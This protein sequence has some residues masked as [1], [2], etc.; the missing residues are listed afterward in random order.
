VRGDALAINLLDSGRREDHFDAWGWAETTYFGPK[1]GGVYFAKDGNH[2]LRV[3][4]RQDGVFIDAILL[5]PY[6]ELEDL[7]KAKR[8]EAVEGLLRSE[9]VKRAYPDLVVISADAVEK[10]RVHGKWKKRRDSTTLFGARVDDLPARRRW[11][12]QPLVNPE[13]YFEVDFAARGRLRYHLWM[14]MKAF[15]GSPNNDSVYSQ[16]SDVVDES[17]RERYRI[18][19]PAHA[20]SRL[21]DVNLILV[22]HT[23]GGQVRIPFYGPLETMTSIGKQYTAGLYRWGEALIYVSRGVG[24]SHI[25][26]RFLCPPEI[27]VFEFR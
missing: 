10:E 26:I 4:S 6:Q 19:R 24:T 15:R 20:K 12:Y 18:G 2:T 21:K 13:N 5:N 9:G 23:H 17:G 25:P 16:F 22:G 7:L 3:Q 1:N 11:Q 27:S 8:V 14:R